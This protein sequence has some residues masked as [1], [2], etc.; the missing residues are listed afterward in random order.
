MPTKFL[1]NG[2]KKE[3][4]GLVDEMVSYEQLKFGIRLFGELKKVEE[5]A[6]RINVFLSANKK[7]IHSA[8]I[9]KL[10]EYYLASIESDPSSNEDPYGE[11]L[12]E[13]TSK[14]RVE[15]AKEEL[16]KHIKTTM[17]EKEIL[18]N[19]FLGKE[20]IKDLEEEIRT[21]CLKCTGDVQP[22]GKIR[23]TGSRYLINKLKDFH[24]A[25]EKTVGQSYVLPQYWIHTSEEFCSTPVLKQSEEGRMVAD[26][27]HK[28]MGGFS[29]K[30]ISRIQNMKF[31]KDYCQEK[32]ALT[33]L[34]QNAGLSNKIREEFLWH[35]TGD[36]SPDTLYSGFEEC[37][38]IQYATDG[39]WGR[40]L[41]FSV[42]ASYSDDCSHTKGTGTRSVML[43]KVMVGDSIRLSANHNLRRA[44]L[45]SSGNGSL[46]IPYDSVRGGAGNSEI[47]I[48]YRMRRA[49][50][51]YHIEYRRRVHG[52]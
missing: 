16:N 38:D 3:I 4:K 15:A 36:I 18:I 17:A 10:P 32:D 25:M 30:S 1:F 48:L 39:N 23:V 26:K 6:Q 47:Y 40:G 29:I 52:R 42:E 31:W 19:P 49:Y 14:N 13:G 27:F 33:K 8:V 51:L 12:I 35:G 2:L 46:S 24:S 50:P 20:S 21:S 34:H 22:G 44:P 41:Y 45:R 37:F 43:C 5:S 28:T 11:I 9:P 7:S